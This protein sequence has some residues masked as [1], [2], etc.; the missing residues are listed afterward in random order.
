MRAKAGLMAFRMLDANNDRKLQ[1]PEIER[2]LDTLKRAL[3]ASRGDHLTPEAWG[4]LWGGAKERGPE[5]RDRRRPGR[6][7]RAPE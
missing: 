1:P 2:A 3:E 6:P 7:D 5:D 4:R